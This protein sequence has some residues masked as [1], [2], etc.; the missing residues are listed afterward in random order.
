M[1]D[2]GFVAE[3]K[4]FITRGNVLDMAIG[5]I[6]GGAFNAIVNSLVNDIIS[7]LIGLATGGI[8]FADLAIT[9]VAATAETEAVTINIGLFINA[10]INFLVIALT[11]FVIIRS[12]NKFNEIRTRKEREEAAKA[13]AA[14]PPAKSADIL[15]L[16][17]IRDLLK[18]Q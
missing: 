6:I 17:E 10:I 13:A 14:A 1:K 8:D 18:R 11:L 3:F 12:F 5:V 15:L 4:K 9:L 16:E 7:P 2:K